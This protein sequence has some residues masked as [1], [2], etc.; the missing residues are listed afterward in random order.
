MLIV[1]LGLS[2]SPANLPNPPVPNPLQPNPTAL[3]VGCRSRAPKPD[4]DGSVSVPFLQNPFNSTRSEKERRAAISSFSMS[5]LAQFGRFRRLKHQIRRFLIQ[6]GGKSIGFGEISAKS[7]Q[8]ALDL[9]RIGRDL[10]E[11]LLFSSSSAGFD[12]TRNRRSPDEKPTR[13][14]RP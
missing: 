3:V 1:R 12:L 5:F 13:K 6:F 10:V 14:T 7:G 9:G 4:T 8:I 2:I 11:F